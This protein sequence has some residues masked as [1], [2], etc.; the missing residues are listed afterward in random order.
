MGK[1][2]RSFITFLAIVAVLALTRGLWMPL[3]ARFLMV[4]DNI[5][6]ADAIVILSGDWQFER[7]KRAV[8]LY[9]NG[10]ADKIIRILETENMGFDIIKRLLN[11]DATQKEVYLG[12]F[13]SSGASRN[14]IILG[15]AVATSTFDEL[16]A[17]K[18]I[19]LKNNFSSIILVTSG[20]HM[21]RSLMTAKWVFR[22][23]GVKVYHAT[24]YSRGFNPNRWWLHEV[25]IK[26]VIFE[27]LNSGFYLLYHFMLGK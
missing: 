1:G 25:S 2:K 5:E 11:S 18:D 9:K 27:Y 14:D 6:K 19:V 10:F 7:E 8:E 23:G 16:K 4:G 21:R 13:G 26:E 3:P 17:V 20:Y 15:E 22:S 24:I 12:F